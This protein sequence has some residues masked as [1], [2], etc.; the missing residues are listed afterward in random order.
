MSSWRHMCAG[1]L[2]K[3]LS[4]ILIQNLQTTQFSYL[5]VYSQFIENLNILGEEWAAYE[6][7]QKHQFPIDCVNRNYFVADTLLAGWGF[8]TQASFRA[9]QICPLVKLLGSALNLI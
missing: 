5:K 3:N 7:I 6:E 8:F 4:K 9:L 2:K 1:K